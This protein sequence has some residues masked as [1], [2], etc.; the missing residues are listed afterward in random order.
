[1]TDDENIE[2]ILKVTRDKPGRDAGPL[3]RCPLCNRVI[4]ESLF[5]TFLERCPR[6]GRWIWAETRRKI[7]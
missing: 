4:C 2:I 5:S 7:I 6:C 3:I 1:M